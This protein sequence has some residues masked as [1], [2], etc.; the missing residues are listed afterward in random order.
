MIR[1]AIGDDA[2]A[3]S[4]LH[5]A[6][7]LELCASAY[8]LE[9]RMPWVAGLQPALYVSLLSLRELFVFERDDELLGFCVF[10]LQ[11][12]FV[13]ANYVHPK[14]VRRG[15]GKQLM[16]LAELSLRDRGAHEVQL[17]ATLNAVPFYTALGY[18]ELGLTGNR[19]PSGLELPCMA[20]R[21]TLE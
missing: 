21:K 20:M 14:A 17:H 5:R 13:H 9:Q 16:A 11:T 18:R 8:S 3:L 1:R 2:S 4:A 10:D 12:A 15:I 19:L 7:I 6:S